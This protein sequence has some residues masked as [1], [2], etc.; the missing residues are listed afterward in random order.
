MKKILRFVIKYLVLLGI[1]LLAHFIAD[2]FFYENRSISCTIFLVAGIL[3][4]DLFDAMDN[5]WRDK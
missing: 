5:I 4:R 1:L 3:W 2:V